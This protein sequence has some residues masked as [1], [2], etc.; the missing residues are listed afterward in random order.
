MSQACQHCLLESRFAS[1]SPTVARTSLVPL[2]PIL[3]EGRVRKSSRKIAGLDGR[4]EITESGRDIG[5]FKFSPGAPV[6]KLRARRDKSCAD[7]PSKRYSWVQNLSGSP[8]V[9][10]LCHQTTCLRAS[11]HHYEHPLPQ[12]THPSCCARVGR[13]SQHTA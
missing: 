2:G 13:S 5:I 11:G 3:E 9:Q 4:P 10:Y 1:T 8:P 6:G 7:L 12:G